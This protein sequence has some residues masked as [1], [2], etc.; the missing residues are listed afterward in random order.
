LHL[1]LLHLLPL[2]E[3]LQVDLPLLLWLL[4]Q[5]PALVERWD[6][7]S[8]QDQTCSGSRTDMLMTQA[9]QQ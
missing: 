9:Q 4:A 7:G 6:P 3:L 1:L 5:W 8:E 2:Q